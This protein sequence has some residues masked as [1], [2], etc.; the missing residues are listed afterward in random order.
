MSIMKN[1]KIIKRSKNVSSKYNMPI[2]TC[3][4]EVPVVPVVIKFYIE[5]FQMLLNFRDIEQCELWNVYAYLKSL[6]R[7]K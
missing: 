4:T 1:I 3:I 7:K 6:N 5:R 2:I